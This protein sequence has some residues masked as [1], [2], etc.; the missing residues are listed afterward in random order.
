MSEMMNRDL[1]RMHEGAA[2]R[3]FR[4][5]ALWYWLHQQLI[6]GR[7]LD[8]GGGSGYMT[9]K[10]LAEGREVT[11]AEPEADLI[12]FARQQVEKCG[13]SARFE[14]VNAPV[15]A[16]ESAQIGQFANI[17]CLD[18]LEHIEDDRQALRRL[19]Q[20]IEPNG[21]ILISVPAIP[22][23]YGTRDKAYGHYRRHTARSLR[24]LITDCGLECTGLRYWNLLGVAPYYFYERV[25]KKPV[26]DSLRQ[27][28]DTVL[29][30]SIRALLTGWLKL[31]TR[32]PLW[33]G[34]SLL[35]VTR[36][37]DGTHTA[38]H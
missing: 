30:R 6:P 11:L 20:L 15:E 16:L 8:V 29:A 24:T 33:A 37:P 21:R 32:L 9:L 27:G 10:L 19:T 2:Q 1:L 35:A 5:S 3:D 7:T 4:R 36:L 38:E 17:V 34:L 25:L 18:V 13:L 26:N 31:E 14:A 12:L 23:L 22:A 28:S